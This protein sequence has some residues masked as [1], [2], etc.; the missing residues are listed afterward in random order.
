MAAIAVLAG[1][2]LATDDGRKAGV[3]SPADSPAGAGSDISKPGIPRGG[4]SP[5]D[6]LEVSN[7]HP[8][9]QSFAGTSRQ[10]VQLRA[11]AVEP[12][13]VL[14]VLASGKQTVKERVQQL[15][16]MR[17]ILLSRVERESAL[18]FIEGKEVPEG[19]GKGS[20]AVRVTALSIAG[21]G[22][23]AEM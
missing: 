6:E 9:A 4:R 10:S 5:S 22:G 7:S 16:G 1:L 14:G 19:M 15:Q 8:S 17:G 20:L 21:D 18:A 13:A 12:A 3:S 11:K 2:W 23:G